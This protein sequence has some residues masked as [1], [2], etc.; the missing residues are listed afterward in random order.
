M[1]AKKHKTVHFRQNIKERKLGGKILVFS[2]FLFM[3]T[4]FWF[5]SVLSKAYTTTI[6]Y[7]VA[8]DNFPT[9]KMLVNQKELPT[10]LS[11]EINAYGFTLLRHKLTASFSPIEINIEQLKLHRYPKD[12][13]HFFLL[14]ANTQARI[15]KQLPSEIDILDV[16]P[17]TIHFQ[18][19]DVE[20]KKVVVIPD[21]DL[22]LTQQFFLR[23]PIE[24]QPDSILI[25]GPREVIKT[26]D[27]IYTKH[28]KWSGIESKVTRKAHLKAIENVRFSQETVS[29][30]IPVEQF[31][32]KRLSVPITIINRPDSLTLKTFP[33]KADLSFMVSFSDY[34]QISPKDF[35][36]T[37]SFSEDLLDTDLAPNR[38][39]VKVMKNP[40]HIRYLRYSPQK[41]EYIIEK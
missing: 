29:L 20:Y 3:A 7:P 34:D 31:T 36:L 27:T 17:D 14:T 35:L 18:L 33:A 23:S 41:V 10:H 15:A 25:T 4:F 12:S 5:L 16:W 19:A 8:Y 1:V 21:I 13:T 6:S 2:F 22:D 40:D 11:I 37:V 32:E 39:N 28:Y 24:T 30:T 26:I 38:L 9:D